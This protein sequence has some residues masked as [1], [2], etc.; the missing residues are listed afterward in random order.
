VARSYESLT[1]YVGTALGLSSADL[2][3]AYRPAVESDLPGILALRREVIGGMWWDDE[4][5]VRWRYFV[6]SNQD[7]SIPFWVF[8]KDGVIVGACGLEPVTLSIDGSRVPAVRTLDIMVRPDLDG[9]GLGAFM[10]LALF[11]HFPITLVTGSNQKSHQLLSRMFHHTLDMVFW[12]IVIASNEVVEERLGSLPGSRIISGGADL[13]LATARFFQR[14][15]VPQG[16]EIRELTSFDEQASDLSRRCERPGRVFVHRH[17]SYLNWR[18][19]RNPRCRYSAFGAFR[20]GRLEGYL[21]TRL[22][23]ARANPRREAEVVDWLAGPAVDS[24]FWPLPSLVATGL[25]H[26]VQAGAGLVTCAAHDPDI[27]RAMAINGF[28]FR[29]GQVLPFF[30]RAAAAP[31]HARLASANGWF[32][33]RGD[34]DVE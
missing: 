28:V 33:T 11:R 31:V 20:D 18:F 27:E 4:A 1:P 9:L 5:F 29:P 16:L 19:F 22:N 30:V 10:N 15:T 2:E 14:A 7:G 24:P 12:K 34:L 6:L 21:V 3:R 13:L 23:L 8:V 32:V 26:L 25:E 17:A